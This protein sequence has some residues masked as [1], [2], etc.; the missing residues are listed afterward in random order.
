MVGKANK[1]GGWMVGRVCLAWP[2]T[3]SGSWVVGRGLVRTL[4]DEIGGGKPR[5]SHAE[6]INNLADVQ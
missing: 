3:S 1:D 5:R 4:E 2:K 6:V